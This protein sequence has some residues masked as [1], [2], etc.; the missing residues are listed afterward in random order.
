[1]NANQLTA[2]V[3]AIRDKHWGS[4][5]QAGIHYAAPN[6]PR[7]CELCDLLTAID[8]ARFRNW[9]PVQGIPLH[10][11]DRQEVYHKALQ[12]VA[13]IV[14]PEVVQPF[15]WGQMVHEIVGAALENPPREVI[16]EPL[17]RQSFAATPTGSSEAFTHM[18]E[19]DVDGPKLTHAEI[20][21]RLYNLDKHVFNIREAIR[22]HGI[23]PNWRSSRE[24]E[25]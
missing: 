24:Q 17:F 6:A 9:D 5:E 21:E 19:S 20:E 18:V 4:E 3:N 15:G 7:D 10:V 16:L 22:E 2:R 23:D 11:N 13:E 14:R 25:R 1:M 8:T 12:A